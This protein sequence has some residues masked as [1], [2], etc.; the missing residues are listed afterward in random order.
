MRPQPRLGQSSFTRPTIAILMVLGLQISLPSSAAETL[1]LGSRPLNLIDNLAAGE[2]QNRLQKCASSSAQTSSF[3]ISH[4]GA[5]LRFP[6]H[7][8]E[9][10][11]AAARMGA[12]AIECDVTFTSDLALVCRHSQ[13]DLHS[14]TNILQT[15]LA[16]RCSVPPD[17]ASKT[18]YRRVKCCTT[19]ITLAEFK[20]LQGKRDVANKDATTLDDY[21]TQINPQSTELYSGSG[22][23]MTHAESIDLFKSLGV[24]MIPELKAASVAM[25][26]NE[27]FSQQRYAQAL[28]DEYVSAN[29]PASDVFLQSFNLEDI[30]YW[31]NTNPEFG[32]QAAWLDGRF[33]DRSF[34]NDKAKSWQP[35]MQ[36]LTAQ[37]VQILAPPI[38]ML[39]SLDDEQKIVPSVYAKAAKAAGLDL[40]T[41]SLERSGSLTTG[42]GWYYKTIKPAINQDSDIYRVLDVLARDVGVRGVFSDWPATVTYYANCAGLK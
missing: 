33:S 15:P 29:V 36:D 3:S 14:T 2:L 11:L 21:Y 42:G 30:L 18:P 31:I 1:Q 22:T 32:Q 9:G 20:T 41:W 6:E 26:Y 24:K 7:T 19:D 17:P 10:Y 38:W 35:S 39:L 23:L 16:D 12:G 27:D 5:P 40:I 4:R 13:C 37:G 28:V 8:K 25:P 34:R